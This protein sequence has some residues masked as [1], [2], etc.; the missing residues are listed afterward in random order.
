MKMMM[1]FD[2]PSKYQP[3]VRRFYDDGDYSAMMEIADNCS[4][5]AIEV[6]FEE[7]DE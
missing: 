1:I 2:V 6:A 3:M 5:F 4:D 7:G